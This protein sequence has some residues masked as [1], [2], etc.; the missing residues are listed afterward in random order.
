MASLYPYLILIGMSII[1]ATS[2]LLRQARSRAGITNELVQL[3]Q[4]LGF[5]LPDFLRLCWQPLQKAGFKGV[6]W[7]LDWFG[8]NLEMSQGTFGKVVIERVLKVQDITL[9][10]KLHEGKRRF[11]QRYFSTVLAESFFL[12][13]YT[14]MWVKLGT[15]QGAFAQTAKM[16]VFLQHDM[17]NIVQLVSLMAE[18]LGMTP[19]GQEQKLMA[20]LKMVMPTLRDRSERFL[21]T[22]SRARPSD[23]AESINLRD[24]LAKTSDIHNLTIQITG[25]GTG[26]IS[27]QSLNS[28]LDNVFGNYIDQSHRN[29]DKALDIDILITADGNFTEVVILDRLG[30][31][32]KW[33]ERLFEPFWSEKGDGLGIGLYHARQLVHEIGG[34]LSARTPAD[35]P[36]RFILVIPS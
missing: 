2:W 7:E 23:S 14:D 29:P 34:S 17:K 11:E 8:S 13:L 9:T 3:N 15:V 36:L 5:D 33:P 32:C 20:S 12:L 19:A 6:S 21:S 1:A 22:L 10:I 25:D 27:E 18:Q 26:L 24:A 4:D 31:P 16:N 35:G 28:L 30:D